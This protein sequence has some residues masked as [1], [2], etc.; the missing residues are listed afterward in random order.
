MA[1]QLSEV[2][3]H[4]MGI[5]NLW[6][7]V[8]DDMRATVWARLTHHLTE[9]ARRATR[10]TATQRAALSVGVG[11]TSC[12][13]CGI[14]KMD[15]HMVDGHLWA[16]PQPAPQ[17][18][19]D[20]G[21]RLI[22]AVNGIRRLTD[23]STVDSDNT[24]EPSL[25]NRIVSLNG[26]LDHEPEISITAHMSGSNQLPYRWDVVA[27]GWKIDHNTH[28][29]ET[30]TRIDDM[31]PEDLPEYMLGR[32]GF[33]CDCHCGATY[34]AF[35]DPAEIDEH[36]GLRHMDAQHANDYG[37]WAHVFIDSTIERAEEMAAQVLPEDV[38][39][40][41]Y[42]APDNLDDL[43]YVFR[44]T[45]PGFVLVHDYLDLDPTGEVA[46]ELDD[47]N[48]GAKFTKLR[49]RGVEY[50]NQ[51]ITSIMARAARLQADRG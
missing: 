47:T 2:D 32:D 23:P 41:Y 24:T 26:K 30:T 50:R 33:V 35:N 5:V 8:P 27:D 3:Q 17:V 12:L 39:P 49:S 48:G 14:A 45:H 29:R 13:V 51:H 6:E 31:D 46:A 40:R 11:L 34:V 37:A 10:Y 20:S 43:S 16:D 9:T 22:D 38:G 21:Q 36:D 7:H 1:K 44:F 15:H 42:L 4:V 28:R 19:I 25:R 18:L